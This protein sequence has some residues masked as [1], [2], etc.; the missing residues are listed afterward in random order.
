MASR[1]SSLTA[2]ETET[3]LAHSNT[4]GST[5]DLGAEGLGFGV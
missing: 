5:Q 3:A 2:P 4:D 1:W